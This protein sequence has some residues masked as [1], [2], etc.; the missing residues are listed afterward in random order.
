MKTRYIIIKEE[1]GDPVEFDC[2]GEACQFI[3]DNDLSQEVLEVIEVKQDQSGVKMRL[4]AWE[5]E[6]AE[7]IR[8]GEI[9]NPAELTHSDRGLI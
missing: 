3:H 9:P 7:I 8:E 4:M 1:I 2:Y 6:V 5:S